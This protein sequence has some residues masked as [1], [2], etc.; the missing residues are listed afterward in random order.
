[1]KRIILLVIISVTLISCSQQIDQKDLHNL[2]GYWE[3]EKVVMA[4]GT[5]KAYKISETIDHFEIKKD[6]GFR[7]KVK[8]QFDGSYIASPQ[9]EQIRIVDSN[10]HYYL[11]YKMPSGTW[12][13]QIVRLTDQKLVLKN[14]QQV[15]YHYKKPIPFT[16]K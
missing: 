4:D 16:Q 3:I 13:E 6:T 1:M 9:A 10:A 14:E 7:R 5:D 2:N 15:S 12:R 8:P 11:E